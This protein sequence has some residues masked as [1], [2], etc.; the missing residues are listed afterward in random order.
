MQGFHSFG[1]EILSS[2]VGTGPSPQSRI[3]RLIMVGMDLGWGTDSCERVFCFHPLNPALTLRPLDFHGHFQSCSPHFA[4]AIGRR[5]F[6]HLQ[7]DTGPAPQGLAIAVFTIGKPS[8][9]AG[10]ARPLPSLEGTVLKQRCLLLACDR[11]NPIAALAFDEVG[12]PAFGLKGGE[13]SRLRECRL[14]RLR[15]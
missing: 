2:P 8:A 1:V 5:G 7:P 3:L 12:C 13:G 15:L 4:F 6:A 11:R 14:R 9:K 10:G